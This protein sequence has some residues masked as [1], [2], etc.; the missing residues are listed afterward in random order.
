MPQTLFVNAAQIVTCAGPGRA[1]RGAEIRDAGVRA[2]YAALIEGD[3]IA[4]V[5]PQDELERTYPR[6]ERVDCRGGVLMP[7]LVDSHTHG[8]FGKPRHEEQE[9]RASGMGYMEN[10]FRRTT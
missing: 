3:H 9:L 2:G 6:A 1:R 10:T 8:I 7:G 5:A 4:A